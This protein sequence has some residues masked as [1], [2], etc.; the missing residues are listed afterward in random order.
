MQMTIH[1]HAHA[2]ILIFS[3]SV[4]VVVVSWEHCIM[5]VDFLLLPIIGIGMHM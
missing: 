4:E 5:H 2:I 3:F 1:W